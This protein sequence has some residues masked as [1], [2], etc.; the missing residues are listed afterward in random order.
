MSYLI[1]KSGRADKSI[2]L[3]RLVAAANNVRPLNFQEATYCKPGD[4]T[5]EEQ[6]YLLVR[7]LLCGSIKP[8]KGNR[9]YEISDKLKSYMRLAG[10]TWDTNRLLYNTF[11]KGIAKVYGI[12]AI[13]KEKVDDSAVNAFLI[14]YKKFIDDPKYTW[15]HLY[16]LAMN[17]SC[18][19]PEMRAKDNARHELRAMI[20]E[21]T[22]KDIEKS[23]CPEA[24]IDEYL[25]QIGHDIWFDC[26]GN[27]VMGSA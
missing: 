9:Y 16:R 21:A 14:A 10:V 15:D 8:Y 13:L 23:E 7:D 26:S 20:R 2:G 12:K 22:G 25:A 11:C 17:E 6:A 18:H 5:L 27:L 3:I 24:V 4:L 19:S 1:L